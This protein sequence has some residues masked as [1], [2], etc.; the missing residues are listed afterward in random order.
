M[1]DALPSLAT[2]FV[3]LW[4]IAQPHPATVGEGA[5]MAW[6][7]RGA[8]VW[9]CGKWLGLIGANERDMAR[10]PPIR[11]GEGLIGDHRVDLNKLRARA[12]PAPPP[13]RE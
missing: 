3:A 11:A 7:E 8:A 1:T 12:H 9:E 13:C 10:L 6:D 2:L 5:W 4:L